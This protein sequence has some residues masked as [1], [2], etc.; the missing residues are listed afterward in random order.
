MQ[1]AVEQAQRDVQTILDQ[2][3]PADWV[4]ASRAAK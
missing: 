4:A 3:L 2:E 1:T